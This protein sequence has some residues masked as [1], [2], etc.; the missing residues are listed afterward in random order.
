MELYYRRGDADGRSHRGGAGGGSGSGRQGARVETVVLFLPDVWSCLPTRLEWDA[1][2]TGYRRQLER[3]LKAGQEQD[4]DEQQQGDEKASNFYIL[5]SLPPFSLSLALVSH[6]CSATHCWAPISG[7]P[8]T[9]RD[10]ERQ[11]GGKLKFEYHSF[12]FSSS[13]SSAR[14]RA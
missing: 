6:V 10:A 7:P 9:N 3:K 11:S 8:E 4:A 1:L 2:Q 13:M 12:Y 14:E 5:F